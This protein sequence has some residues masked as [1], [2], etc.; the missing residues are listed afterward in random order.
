M[1]QVQTKPSLCASLCYLH[2]G[3]PHPNPP[4]QEQ[5]TLLNNFLPRQKL[6]SKQKSKTMADWS[7]DSRLNWIQSEHVGV[8][9][10][11]F[12][13]K[14]IASAVHHLMLHTRRYW[15]ACVRVRT[16]VCVW[17]RAFL[18]CPKHSHC[19]V[20]MHIQQKPIPPLKKNDSMVK[21][22]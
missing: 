17:V 6:D 5:C 12:S 3:L 4:K 15:C 7:L 10:P 20:R 18:H 22:E 13:Q 8:V 2:P 9:S 21:W 1:T 19:H 14:T 16:R 11:A